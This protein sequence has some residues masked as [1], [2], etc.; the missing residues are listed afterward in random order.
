MKVK[1]CLDERGMVHWKD[2]GIIN[3]KKE[4]NKKKKPSTVEARPDECHLFLNCALLPAVLS[5]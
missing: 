3:K 1:E 4:Q 5:V 2:W